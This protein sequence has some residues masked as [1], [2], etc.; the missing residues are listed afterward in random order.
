VRPNA[1][2]FAV[3]STLLLVIVIP[4]SLLMNVT[5]DC[6]YEVEECPQTMRFASFALLV[7]AIL[8]IAYWAFRYFRRDP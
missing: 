7:S 3:R 4:L 2:E 1:R 6:G 8:L 5:G